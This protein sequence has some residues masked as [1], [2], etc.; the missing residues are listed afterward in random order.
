VC[1]RS[2]PG[3]FKDC[4]CVSGVFVCFRSVCVFQE[5]ARH[6]QGLFVCFRSVP[7][8]FKDCLCVSGVCQASSTVRWS[9]PR[10]CTCGGSRVPPPPWP[11]PRRTQTTWASVPHRHTVSVLA[12]TTSPLASQV[13]MGRGDFFK[14]FCCTFRCCITLRLVLFLSLLSKQL[15]CLA[16]LFFF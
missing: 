10:V 3:I 15:F 9:L 12:S 6:L 2:V 8:V 5:S 1:F 13:I 4:L 16:L 7:G 14:S 11:M